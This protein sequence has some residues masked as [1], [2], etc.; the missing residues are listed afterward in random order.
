MAPPGRKSLARELKALLEDQ[1][2][3]AY[4]FGRQERR[5]LSEPEEVPEGTVSLTP[6]QV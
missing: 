5:E 6:L 3:V 1:A 4:D 2:M